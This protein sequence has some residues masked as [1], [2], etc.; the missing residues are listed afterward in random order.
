MAES[1]MDFFNRTAGHEMPG[2]SDEPWYNSEGDCILYHWRQDEFRGEWIDDKLTLYRAIDSG[3]AVGCQIKGVRALLQKLGDFAIS[4]HEKDGLPL[5]LFILVS[6][7]S[8]E[9]ADRSAERGN[10]YRYLLEQ[11]GKRKVELN[12]AVFA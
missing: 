3:E 5:A 4:I 6:H 1:L 8:G 7:T 9:P 2:F 10:T 11:V 12:V